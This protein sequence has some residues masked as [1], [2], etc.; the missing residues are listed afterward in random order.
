MENLEQLIGQAVSGDK[1]AQ[2]TLYNISN[3]QVFYTC[4]GIVKNETDAEDIM[5]D[6]YMTVFQKLDTLS[7]PNS[8]QA[9]VNRIAVTRC[10]NFVKKCR[11]ISLDEELEENNREIVDEELVLPDDYV[12]DKAKAQILQGII[13]EKLSDVQRETI[14]MYYFHEMKVEDIAAEMEC[15]V[16]TVNT[17]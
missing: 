11:N 15:P 10:M 2:S 17:A 3:K 7:D 9:W 14:L 4:L 6:V 13:N 1:A 5:Q 16:G 8:F 12:S